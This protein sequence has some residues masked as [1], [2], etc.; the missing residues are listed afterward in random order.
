MPDEDGYACIR[1]AAPQRQD[2][3]AVPSVLL[4]AYA[5]TKDGTGCS[6]PLQAT[7]QAVNRPTCARPRQSRTGRPAGPRRRSAQTEKMI[8]CLLRDSAALPHRARKS[9]CGERH[10]GVPSIFAHSRGLFHVVLHFI[11]TVSAQP[12]L[13]R[14]DGSRSPAD[15]IVGQRV[16]ARIAASPRRR[17]SRQG[18]R[19]TGARR[20]VTL[21][22]RIRYTCRPR[23]TPLGRTR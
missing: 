16:V 15:V 5:G 9:R 21:L 20:A 18:R 3:G 10:E 11:V 4:T 12:T 2:G 19:G 1:T 8:L 14:R 6:P 13:V 23:L 7:G 22:R 17:G